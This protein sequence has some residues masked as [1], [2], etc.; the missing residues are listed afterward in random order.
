M[1]G[2]PLGLVYSNAIEWVV[3]KY[4]LHG[5]GKRK[6]SF[7]AFH[8]VGHHRNSRR[9]G[10][11][12]SDYRKPLS[13]WNG[14]G[15]EAACIGLLCAAHLPLAGVWP[16]FTAAVCYSGFNYL[17]KHR[18]AHLDP[19]WA[20]KHMKWHVDHHMGKNQD[21]N[22]CV[23]KP[24]FDYVLG[25]RVHYDVESLR[26]EPKSRSTVSTEPALSSSGG[27]LVGD[28][29]PVEDNEVADASGATTDGH[30]PPPVAA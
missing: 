26:L 20:L 27:S 9:H 17:Y 22:W 6:G 30:L 1:I 14:R 25:T 16:Y 5:L 13:D 28:P 11:I 2:F 10:M 23:T 29:A 24:W 15:K 3:H 8:W 4:A 18:K 12:D 19:Q 7:W 21:A